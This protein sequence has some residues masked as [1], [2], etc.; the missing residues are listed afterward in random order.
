M[1]H[2]QQMG[3]GGSGLKTIK[4]KI[5]LCPY[6]TPV[7]IGSWGWDTGIAVLGVV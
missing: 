5:V 4:K 1:P 2:I 7:E 3:K 6:L